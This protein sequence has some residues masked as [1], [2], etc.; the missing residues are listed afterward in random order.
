LPT[1]QERPAVPDREA[2]RALYDEAVDEINST[3][4]YKLNT[5]WHQQIKAAVF[6][7]G[8]TALSDF[9]TG[10]RRLLPLPAPA[11]SGKTTFFYAFIAAV[12][13]YAEKNRGAAYG[14]AFVADQRERADEVFRDLSALLPD[15]VA[16][17]TTD[18]DPKCTNPEKVKNPA[19]R[20]DRDALQHR[21]VAVVTHEGYL[22]PKG[23]K[24]QN[25]RRDGR[26]LQYPR[27]LT[28]MD[29]Q[30]KEVNVLEV[31]LAEAERVRDALRETHPETREHLDN[32]LRFLQETSYAA[33]NRLIRPGVDVAKETVSAPL[34]WF[35]TREA[36]RLAKQDI[37]GVE[38]VFAY[39][40]A[41]VQGVGF[42]VSESKHVRYV[43]Y[44]SKL[45]RN[46]SAGT[47]L[48]DATADIDGISR[49]V[50]E[51]MPVEVPQARY[52]NLDIIHV[53]PLTT[54]R[55]DQFLK[56]AANRRAYVKW[57]EQT[58]IKN[59]APGERGLV[60]CKLSLFENE[61]VPSWPAGDERFKNA[62][63]YMKGY[64]WDVEGRKLCAIHW[65]TGIGSNHWQDADVVFLFGEFF[66]PRRVSAAK[67]QGYR[68]QRVDQGELANMGAINAKSPGVDA[69]ANGHRL[70][71]TKQ[72]ALRG[73]ARCYDEHG[74]CG[75]Q[76]LVVACD[77][78]S[79]M[80]NVGT[81]FPGAKVRTAR[82][83]GFEDDTMIDKI[84]KRL[85]N[86][87]THT[88]TVT[89]AEIGKLIGK[90]W[91]KAAHRILTPAFKKALGGIGWR[92]VTQR[93]RG[94]SRFERVVV[95]PAPNVALAA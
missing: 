55:L 54:R 77:F 59:T 48:L 24:A 33:A 47:V 62:D 9:H 51:R 87:S 93:G 16:V 23:Y 35:L 13:R 82:G 12:T 73:H 65:G 95:M 45:I 8:F 2:L 75:E 94:G 92:Y 56:T 22:G 17:W 60:V 42:V 76:R 84:I 44:S 34:A 19:A 58:I 57:M 86:E 7:T 36:E 78:Q 50:P 38:R 53:P 68:E 27:A 81:L 4:A 1:K 6:E 90:E 14:C 40:R 52:E 61:C 88:T 31:T 43:W 63:N 5:A 29:E 32:L 26:F 21:P 71:W 72:L 46:L 15:K 20:F 89:T 80:A 85:N 91:R 66:V 83:D 18:H 3:R 67:V 41:L 39:A 74:M 11:G 64:N 79:F 69:I 49:I 28:V 37:P 70:R 30:P 10:T 25:V